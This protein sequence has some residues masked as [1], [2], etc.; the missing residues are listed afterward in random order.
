MD[1]V[2]LAPDI[3]GLQR[4]S[5]WDQTPNHWMMARL[6]VVTC[7]P[8][9]KVKWLRLPPVLCHSRSPELHG[10]RA[11]WGQEE[12]TQHLD[13]WTLR[14]QKRALAQESWA[15]GILIQDCAVQT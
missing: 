6:G 4:G 10:D 13:V 11:V 2:P 5:G 3:L 8:V 15:S 12:G 14:R 1:T 9:T 7:Q